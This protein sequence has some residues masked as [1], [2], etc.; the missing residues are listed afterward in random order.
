MFDHTYFLIEASFQENPTRVCQ[1]LVRV[2]KTRSTR[3]R[4]TPGTLLLY[5]AGSSF[6]TKSF[7]PI[8]GNR[9]ILKFR[10]LWQSTK[11][12]STCKFNINHTKNENEVL[13]ALGIAKG[14]CGDSVWDVE[15][16]MKF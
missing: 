5:F 2:S 11:N 12:N 10:L 14:M 16:E 8:C 7:T 3:S 6:S 4:H 13:Q 9:E 15:I 1:T